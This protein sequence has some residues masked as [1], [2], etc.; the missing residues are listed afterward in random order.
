MEISYNNVL[1][2]VEYEYESG[3]RPTREHPGSPEDVHIKKIYV[4][5]TDWEI[6]DKT[7]AKEDD[8]LREIILSKLAA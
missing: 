4:S 2:W 3:E 6:T 8:Q 1:L 7:T 5:G